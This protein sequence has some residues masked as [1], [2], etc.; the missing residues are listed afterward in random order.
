MRRALARVGVGLGL[1]VLAAAL[2]SPWGLFD[3]F[4]VA[5][6]DAGALLSAP[7]EA[8]R[9]RVILVS[10]DGLAPRFLAAAHTP[11]LDAF[12]EGGTHA[13]E[14]LT[15]RPPVTLPSHA[16]MLTGRPPAEHGLTW[17]RYEPWRG[18]LEGGLFGACAD[19]A[20][21]CGLFAGKRKFVHLGGARGVERYRYVGH[22][23]GILAE[24]LDYVRAQ[25][26][27]FLL[28]HLPEV[29]T[30]GHRHGWG[31]PEQRA[32]IEA[33]DAA[34][35]AFAAELA[36]GAARP[37]TL[38][39]TADHGGDGTEH[40]QDRPENRRI[41]WIAWGDGVPPGRVLD[42]VST[43]DTAPTVAALL[44]LPP[45]VEAAG[46]DRLAGAER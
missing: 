37:L 19:H 39:V 30:S 34:L 22:R 45:L 42:A 20:L 32:E 18:P 41:P 46:R 43:I 29:D 24:A 28:I 25:D 5:S 17:N 6:L 23:D 15:T 4:A 8:N 38:L 27:R 36:A 21:R 9:R 13:R 44:G 26:P 12:A 10:V 1:L 11:H 35:G 2:F 33:V 7:A 3:G 14:A 16:A 31:S 40:H